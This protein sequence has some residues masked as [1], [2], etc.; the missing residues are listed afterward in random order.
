[1]GNEVSHSKKVVFDGTRGILAKHQLYLPSIYHQYLSQKVWDFNSP[2]SWHVDTIL[3]LVW[4][5]EVQSRTYETAVFVLC[6][7]LEN[8]QISRAELRGKVEAQKF[9]WVSARN[10]ILPRLK[11][12]GMVRESKIEGHLTPW[13]DFARFYTKL[14]NEWMREL[15]DRGVRTC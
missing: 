12:L 13:A 14:A 7:I 9:S 2:K 5:P 4:S 1:M 8:Q 11:R 3:K 6:Q 10:V 15:A